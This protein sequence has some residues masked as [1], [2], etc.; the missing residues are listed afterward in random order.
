MYEEILE[1]LQTKVDRTLDIDDFEVVPDRQITRLYAV[2]TGEG[3]D[4]LVNMT[5]KAV[6]KVSFDQWPPQ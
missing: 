4:Y 2:R 1:L 6:Q 3:K 5:A